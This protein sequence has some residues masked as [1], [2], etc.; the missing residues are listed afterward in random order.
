MSDEDGKTEEP[1]DRKLEKAR[2]QGNVPKSEDLNGFMG[3]VFAMITS[4]IY[5]MIYPDRIIDE[6]GLCFQNMFF[7]A[8]E[9]Y[10]ITPE[11][12]T[13]SNTMKEMAYGMFFMMIFA[14]F[15]GYVIMNRGFV[16]SKEPIKFNMQALDIGT[17]LT[18]LIKKE[19]AVGMVISVFK[20]ILFYGV[21]FILITIFMPIMVYETFCFENCMG[22]SSKYYVYM[23][24]IIYTFIAFLFAAIDYPLKVM[25]WKNKLKMSHKDIK[26]EN[27]EMNGSPETKQ[28]QSEFRWE[29]LNG[30]PSG[31]KNATFFVRGGTTMW[32]IRYNR[33]ESPAPIVVAV[34]KDPEK[35]NKMAQIAQ[36]MRRL[37]ISDD[38]FARML[39]GK[40]VQGRP[41]PLEF[42]AQVRRCI[43]E[44]K[45]H[46]EKFGPTHPQK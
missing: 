17:N 31:P 6:L 5:T 28:A 42:V 15:L 7:L 8:A 35:A 20:E 39:Q 34:G 3:V 46:E 43:M 37:V 38:E 9:G 29:M 44:L 32:G 23:L 16:I 27:K 10:N 45:K 12:I 11:C 40:A 1:T 26:D 4:F 36:Q 21:F 41:V 19:N 24:I 25:F 13:F 22:T 2:E 30:I 14:A 33:E 18:G